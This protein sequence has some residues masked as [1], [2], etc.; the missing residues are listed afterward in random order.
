[1]SSIKERKDEIGTILK[2]FYKYKKDI[3]GVADNYKFYSVTRLRPFF[4]YYN[5]HDLNSLLKLT[6]KDVIN[7]LSHQAEIG[8]CSN[9]RNLKLGAIQEVFKYYRDIEKTEVD[10]G[11]MEIKPGKVRQKVMHYL[12]SREAMEFLYFIS[13]ETYYVATAICLLTGIRYY[14]L[15]QFK[16]DD[17]DHKEVLFGKREVVTKDIV[18]KGGRVRKIIIRPWLEKKIRSYIKGQR[19]EIINNTGI[20]TDVLLINR[21]G[22]PISLINFNNALKV[23]AKKMGLSWWKEMSAHKLR[24]TAASIYMELGGNTKAVQ[25]IL[26]HASPAVTETYLH[27]PLE[28]AESL[29]LGEQ[30]KDRT[31]ENFETFFDDNYDYD[32]EDEENGN[33]GN[34]FTYPNDN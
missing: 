29:L 25:Q 16:V 17:I 18:G 23:A 26:G 5:I 12:S 11:I 4:D 24:H 31:L 15:R 6:T 1:M 32:N 20:E 8:N 30:V 10:N 19:A 3:V 34:S 28:V 13:N 22:K 9:S 7:F 21:E 27:S 14:E 2:D 33:D